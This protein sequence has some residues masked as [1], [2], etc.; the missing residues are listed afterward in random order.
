MKLITA[1]DNQTLKNLKSLL[2]AKGRQEHSLFIAEGP[3]LVEEALNAGVE[4]AYVAVSASDEAKYAVLANVCVKKGAE[5]LVLADR[6]FE[7][8]AET[9]T[10]QGILA[11]VRIPKL[12]LD[13][14]GLA[15]GRIAVVMENLQDP[16]NLG[17]ILRTAL[18]VNAS[19][20][21]LCGDCADPWS[22]KAV[23]ASQ[24]AAMHLKI[25]EAVS[26]PEAIGL[27][28]GLG[29][30]TAC[31]HLRGTDFFSRSSH[32]RTAIVIGNETAGVS[33]EAAAA[34]LALYRLPMSG[35][36]ESLNAAVAA[37]IMLYDIFRASG[38]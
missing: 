18:A 8:V 10:P 16:C 9:K 3:H 1:S 22:P 13:W 32:A 24:G 33:D 34:C 29:W 20:A 14:P 36:A 6:L 23:R 27:L 37:G 35:P 4:I 5:G 21:V 25:I 2:T 15:D 26:A 7:A 17:T 11:A 30:H 19:F 31:G 28:N 38:L 12:G